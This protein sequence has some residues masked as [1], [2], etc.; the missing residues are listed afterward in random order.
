MAANSNK[1]SGILQM[2]RDSLAKDINIG[3]G[4]GTGSFIEF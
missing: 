3:E 1:Q 2:T 4:V